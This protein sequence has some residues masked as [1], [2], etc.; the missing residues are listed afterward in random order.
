MLQT[1]E[2]GL[3]YVLYVCILQNTIYKYKCMHLYLGKD[4]YKW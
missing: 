1:S 4:E 2:I 3:I